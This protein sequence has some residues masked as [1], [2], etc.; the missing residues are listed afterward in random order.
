[1]DPLRKPPSKNDLRLVRKEDEDVID[2]IRINV[3]FEKFLYSTLTGAA[4]SAA[5]FFA[6]A[7]A[8]QMLTNG[9]S[10]YVI[11]NSIGRALSAAAFVFLS[12][13]LASVVVVAPIF[14]FMERTKRREPTVYY[15]AAVAC[16]IIFILAKSAIDGGRIP[17]PATLV[18]V[19]ITVT[20]I[21]RNFVQALLPLWRAL[22]AQDMR[23]AQHNQK[24]H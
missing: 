18:I 5:L 19:A 13:F 7:I 17:A 8:D 11:F 22:A 15:A 14:K 12:G 10:V 24:L 21:A 2:E 23:A 9:I 1:M 4:L 16:F 6:Y 3:V 20:F